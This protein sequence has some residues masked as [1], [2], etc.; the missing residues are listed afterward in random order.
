MM[1]TTTGVTARVK[2]MTTTMMMIGRMRR[3]WTYWMES[4]LERRLELHV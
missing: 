3:W 2:T 4:M 1:M